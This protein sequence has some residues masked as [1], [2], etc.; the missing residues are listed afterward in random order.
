MKNMIEEL[1]EGNLDVSRMQPKAGSEYW[2]ALDRIGLFLDKVKEAWGKEQSESLE[3]AIIEF[4]GVMSKDSFI[5]GFQW[6]AK[7]MFSILGDEPDSLSAK[8]PQA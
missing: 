5:L 4:E 1:Y 8:R 3:N 7:L 2:K 6:G